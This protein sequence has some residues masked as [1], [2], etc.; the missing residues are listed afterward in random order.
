MTFNKCL[1]ADSNRSSSVIKIEE[2]KSSLIKSDINWGLTR[3]GSYSSQV[4]RVSQVKLSSQVNLG[5]YD[6]KGACEYRLA[7]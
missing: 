5:L 4:T 1:T 3:L 6:D 7:N 2:T